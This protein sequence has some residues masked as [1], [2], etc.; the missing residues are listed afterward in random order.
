M[1]RCTRVN[2]QFHRSICGRTSDCNIVIVKELVHSISGIDRVDA[3]T[4]HIGGLNILSVLMN[5]LAIGFGG[6][7]RVGGLAGVVGLL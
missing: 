7:V 2:K 3:Y 1:A 6:F 5:V 4:K